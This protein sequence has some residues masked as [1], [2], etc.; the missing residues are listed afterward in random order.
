MPCLQTPEMCTPPQYIIVN[1]RLTLCTIKGYMCLKYTCRLEGS[2][3]WSVPL[4]LWYMPGA[5]CH[6]MT[7][8]TF[9]RH[10]R[11]PYC[12]C[13]LETNTGRKHNKAKV[14]GEWPKMEP[15]ITRKISA[16]VF[17]TTRFLETSQCLPFPRT[18]GT[19]NCLQIRSLER[20]RRRASSLKFELL[21]NRK[22]QPSS[23]DWR[24]LDCSKL[25][26][27]GTA[28]PGKVPQRS[29]ASQSL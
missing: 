2:C 12:Y 28:L 10:S 27:K 5:T 1:P 7:S 19:G 18:F 11:C 14:G 20:L 23:P 29:P 13:W 4:I 9:S 26:G 6:L 22:Q 16:M 17:L 8:I 15:A 25:N 24:N 21:G 3:I